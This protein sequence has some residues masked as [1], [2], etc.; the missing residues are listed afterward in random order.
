MNNDLAFEL[1]VSPRACPV[2]ATTV[3]MPSKGATTVPS[4]G[5]MRIPLPNVLLSDAE[6][7]HSERG[8]TS[9]ATG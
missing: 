5:M 7:E 9:P 6:S 2:S 3:T 8:F 4:E 1:D